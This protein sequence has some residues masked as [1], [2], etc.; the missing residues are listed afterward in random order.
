VRSR[1][2]GRRV[3]QRSW[4]VPRGRVSDLAA[5]GH[6]PRKCEVDGIESILEI[7]GLPERSSTRLSSAA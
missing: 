1:R 2:V 7:E 3:A 4:R 6:A 5:R